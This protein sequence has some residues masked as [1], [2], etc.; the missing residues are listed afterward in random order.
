M[1]TLGSGE[2]PKSNPLGRKHVRRSGHDLE[3]VSTRFPTFARS[4]FQPSVRS[5]TQNLR[6]SW[7]NSQPK[8]LIPE[9]SEKEFLPSIGFSTTL[10]KSNHVQNPKFEIQNPSGPHL[11]HE[12]LAFKPFASWFKN[13]NVIP[14]VRTASFSSG[15]PLQAWLTSTLN[16]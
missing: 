3:I 16:S 9:K 4:R 5:R 10:K 12:R 13:N 2:D 14:F 11:G 6:N 8:D 15:C 1:L 7:G